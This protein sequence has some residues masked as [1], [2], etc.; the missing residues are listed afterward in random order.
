MPLFQTLLFFSCPLIVLIVFLPLLVT[1]L[2]TW[3]LTQWFSKKKK[4]LK[5]FNNTFPQSSNTPL[6]ISIK[7]FIFDL[8]VIYMM[9]KNWV[10]SEPLYSLD[11]YSN[12]PFLSVPPEKNIINCFHLILTGHDSYI[13]G[14]DTGLSACYPERPSL[15]SVKA[16]RI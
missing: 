14:A 3:S 13:E 16:G 15:T 6:T 10:Y 5:V 12:V 2:Q 11:Q 4:T 7:Y 8:N 1:C 9:S